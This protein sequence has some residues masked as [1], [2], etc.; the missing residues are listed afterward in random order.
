[1]SK[2]T[3]DPEVKIDAAPEAAPE[4]ALD[5]SLEVVSDAGITSLEAAK[6]LTTDY[7]V[8]PS[9]P[10]PGDRVLLTAIF[11]RM[12]HPEKPEVDQELDVGKLTRVS[13]DW[14][15]ANLWRAGRIQLGE[16]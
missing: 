7:P 9:M 13:F 12:V 2:T 4:A 16:V 8:A 14:W 15:H 6:A 5:V 1:M 10:A 3:P 11:G